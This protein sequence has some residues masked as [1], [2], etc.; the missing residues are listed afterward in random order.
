MKK[1]TMMRFT[2]AAIAA[3][4]LLGAAA[5]PAKAASG[6][7]ISKANFPD[8]EIRRIAKEYDS[9]KDGYLAS[10]EIKKITDVWIERPV[11][12]YKGIEYFTELK[13]FSNERSDSWHK[14]AMM[15]KKKLDLSKNKK[16]KEVVLETN[17]ISSVDVSGCKQLKSLYCFCGPERGALTRLD[18]TGCTSLKELVCQQSKLKVLDVSTCTN[19]EKLDLY[20][21]KLTSVKLGNIKKL[22][23][24][25]LLANR[26]LKELDVRRQ[27]NLESLVI[28]GT[29]IA[30]IDLKKNKKL[31]DFSC[32][33]TSA[34][35]KIDVSK[36]TKLVNLDCN[37]TKELKK[38]DVSKNINL[39]HLD[40]GRT[41]I[42]KLDLSKNKNLE[43]LSCENTRLKKLDLSKNVNL[44]VLKCR[45]NE[46]TELDLRNTNLRED[47]KGPIYR[48]GKKKN[49][50]IYPYLKCDPSVVVTR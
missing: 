2:M 36:N 44:S 15:N 9:N 40:C 8:K 46:I 20:N 3:G 31:I 35:K 37:N 17:T 14:G 26:P 42:S 48:Q 22:K 32:G 4:L 28:S 11:S 34:M 50:I 13:E 12:N 24:L 39:L 33:Y 45:N 23:N 7:R 25:F 47:K 10:G 41:K 27:T 49:G 21:N 16:L 30:S 6:V 18:V 19:L 29:D 1:K 5:I 43:E 38:L